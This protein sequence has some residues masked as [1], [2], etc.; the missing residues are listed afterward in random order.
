MTKFLTAIFLSLTLISC[1]QKAQPVDKDK[2]RLD[3]VCD[4]FMQTFREGNFPGAMDMLKQNSVMGNS[5][6]DTLEETVKE[7]MTKILPSYG[8][9]V[10]YEFISEH[11]IKDF[12]TRR[13]YIL[14]FEKYYLKFDFTLYNNGK[15]WTIT[16]FNYNEELL[17]LLY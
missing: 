1:G 5:A 6:I 11:N 12:I 8:K 7:Q 10:S 14:K 4:T 9:I 15:G 16:G 17:E 13:F 2:Q 3:K